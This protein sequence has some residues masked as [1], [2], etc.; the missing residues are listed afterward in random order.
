MRELRGILKE[1][2]EHK[3]FELKSQKE[4]ITPAEMQA[5]AE[6]IPAA[7]KK[8]AKA[9]SF[10]RAL[11]K[12]GE[13]S[14]IAEVKRKSPSRGLLRADFNPAEIIKSYT[15]AGA[16]ALSILTDEKFFG[17]SSQYLK[18]GAE[19][20]HLPLLRKDFIIDEYQIYEAA[21]LGACSVLLIARVLHPKTLK[22]FYA[23]AKELGLDALVEIHGEAEL[24]A[25]LEAG[26]RIVGINNRNLE[27]FQT[28]INHT[29]RMREKITVPEIVV[30]SESGIKTYADILTLK[31][32]GVDAVLV[33]ESFMVHPDVGAAVRELR[34]A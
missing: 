23:L 26:V 29:L 8:R 31:S 12:P 1:I 17:G 5:G 28:D 16:S 6:K 20:T 11:K 13:V 2:I 4:R 25:V 34:G 9:K 19:I 27:T 10:Y 33:G 30:V 14:I 32:A 3:I 15:D 22:R 18:L 21:V 7:A 24:I